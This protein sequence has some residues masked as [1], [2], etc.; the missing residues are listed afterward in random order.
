[1]NKVLA[2]IAGTG[3]AAFGYLGFALLSH[4]AAPV[5]DSTVS[6]NVTD[7]V[8]GMNTAGLNGLTDA[9]VGGGVLLVTAALVFWVI[10]HFRAI[11]HI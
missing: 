3:A 11:V 5:A 9:V 4:A 1:M 7:L 8:S 2:K 10:K 6:G